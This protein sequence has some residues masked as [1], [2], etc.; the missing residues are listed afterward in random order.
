LGK[1]L[2]TLGPMQIGLNI[3]IGLEEKGGKDAKAYV[4]S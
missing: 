4:A 2:C 3:V 1:C